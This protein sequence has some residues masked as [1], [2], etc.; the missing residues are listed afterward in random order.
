[1]IEW[2]GLSWLLG[3]LWGRLLLQVLGMLAVGGLSLVTLV[4]FLGQVPTSL[5]CPEEAPSR[6]WEVLGGDTGQ[7]SNSCQ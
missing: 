2:G 5:M 7:Q 1:M 3:R 6:S 4:L